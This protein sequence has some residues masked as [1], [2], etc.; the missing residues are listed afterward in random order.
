MNAIAARK[1]STEARVDMMKY[2]MQKH[3]RHPERMSEKYT[4][5]A[6]MGNIGAGA[7]NIGSP[8]Q[9]T[10]CYLLKA[11]PVNLRSL[12]GGIEKAG[13][14]WMSSTVVSHAESQKL[15]YPEAVW[16]LPHV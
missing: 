4:C 13:A 9:A 8:Q 2:W 3:A 10:F 14:G 16:I 11:D 15:P 7:D 1:S 6:A 12:R 5:C